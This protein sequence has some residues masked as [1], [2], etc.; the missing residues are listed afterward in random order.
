MKFDFELFKMAMLIVCCIMGG[1]LLIFFSVF[2]AGSINTPKA[3]EMNTANAL[4]AGIIVTAILFVL[5]IN[6]IK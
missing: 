6:I 1:V 5:M 3:G 2:L 4:T